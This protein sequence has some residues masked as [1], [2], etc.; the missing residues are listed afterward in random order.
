MCMKVIEKGRRT[1]RLAAIK[2]NGFRPLL[3]VM[4]LAALGSCS[5]GQVTKSDIVERVDEIYGKV[6][7][8]YTAHPDRGLLDSL[9][10]SNDWKT[11]VK[12]VDETVVEGDEMGFFDADYWI[13]GQDW[14]D[15]GADS[16]VV[17]RLD[18][19]EAQ[20]SFDL[21]NCGQTTR[22]RLLLVQENEAWKIDNFIDV[23]NDY[24]WKA[25]MNDYVE[26]AALMLKTDSIGLVKEDADVEVR[27]SAD[28]PT[29]G[30]TA[31][32]VD[33]IRRYMAETMQG[34]ANLVG[35]PE[36]LLASAYKKAYDE[37]K[38]VR[39][40]LLGE[41]E[42]KMPPFYVACEIRKGPDTKKYVTYLTTYGEYQ[43]GAHGS[44]YETGVTFNKSTGRQIG[45]DVLK[46]TGKREFRQLM[47]EG[48][49]EYF[50][51]VG[52]DV[53]TDEQLKEMLYTDAEVD[54]L[55]LPAWAPYL[56]E[57][58]MVFRYQQYEIAAYA[59]GIPTFTIGYDQL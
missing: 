16:I 51:S 44:S 23:T 11:L 7:E 2:R 31:V 35:Q 24:D 34:D 30:A 59:V 38:M 18:E 6:A 32:V 17:E 5:G 58:G 55:P 47:K 49:C 48:L 20:A 42:E 56:T 27:L 54:N 37:L 12:I 43:G 4:L 28:Y 22:V 26:T 8:V 10:C 21:H 45:W 25:N 9:Y 3:G 15:L 50:Q 46:D 52:M 33:S 57:E 36:Q 40:E 14:Q 39:G 53:S 29:G 19:S 1:R 41:T 13:M